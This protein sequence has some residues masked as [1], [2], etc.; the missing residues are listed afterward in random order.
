MLFHPPPTHSLTWRFALHFPILL[1][2]E[3]SPLCGVDRMVLKGKAEGGRELSTMA[4]IISNDVIS[5][6]ES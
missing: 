1:L 3:Y 6:S 5:F 2:L 4:I